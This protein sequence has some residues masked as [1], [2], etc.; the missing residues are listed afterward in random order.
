[1]DNPYSSDR[2]IAAIATPPGEGGIGVIRLSG[3]EA[4]PIANKVFSRDVTRIP[5][6]TVR[7]GK[8]VQ[9]EQVIDEVL[10]VV[11]HAPKTFTGEDVVEIQCH[12][13]SLITKKVLATVLAAGASPAGPGEFTYQAFMNGKVDLT[14]AEAIQTFIGAKNDLALVA[15]GQQL[16]G[17]LSAKV[18]GFQKKL[19]D[20]AATFEA[21]VDFP[22]EG[23]EFSKMEELLA[24][25]QRVKC[26]IEQLVATFHE[27]RKLQEGIKLAIIGP[28]NAGK[29]SLMNALLGQA[30]AIVTPIPGTTRDL[31]EAPLSLGGLHYH[32]V[33]TAGIRKTQEVVEQEG[34]RRSKQTM[35][36]ADLILLVL[37]LSRPLDAQD[38]EIVAMASPA[39]TLLVWNKLD[40]VSTPFPFSWPQQVRLSA[41]T[42]AGLDQLK[43]QIEAMIWAQGAPAKDEIILTNVRHQHALAQAAT[44]LEMAIAGC[45]SRLFPELIA[46]DLRS[47]LTHLASIIGMDI[48]EEVLSEIFSKF[49]VGK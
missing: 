7:Y 16:E 19:L 5:S 21:L 14:Q 44:D 20:A 40:L 22:E 8:V 10:L 25:L 29:S 12:G 42:G 3:K 13:G 45:R 23:L 15:A 9:G 2:T 31:L 32:L 30:R 46:I 24:Q 37:D 18:E 48:S 35:E 34:I 4:I 11:M 38:E 26:E 36:E 39:K 1:M 27:G 33:D 28:P 6:H 49:C 43:R 47:A 17:R 41:Q